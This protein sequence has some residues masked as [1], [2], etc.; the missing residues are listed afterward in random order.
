[1]V[2]YPATLRRFS[3][4]ALYSDLVFVSRRNFR[5]DEVPQLLPLR[6]TK[7]GTLR[8]AGAHFASAVYIFSSIRLIY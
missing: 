3:P 4:F 6:A 5:N 7:N 2:L 1:M 8:A